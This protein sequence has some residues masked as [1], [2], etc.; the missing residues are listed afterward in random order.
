MRRFMLVPAL[1][2][3]CGIGSPVQAG[4]R[5]EADPQGHYPITPGI[6]AFVIC[7]ACFTGDEAPD[8]ARQL[9]Y[10]IR[11]NYN[12]PAY[13]FNRGDEERRRQQEELEAVQRLNLQVN[14]NQPVRRRT[15]RIEEQ[16]AVLVGG[17]PDMETGR[18]AL[19]QIKAMKVNELRLRSGQS[20]LDVMQTVKEDGTVQRSFVNPFTTAFVTRN[21]SIPPD[22]INKF[23]PQL[24]V[25][26]ADEEYS[27]LKCPQRW[28][29]AVKQ[30]AGCKVVQTGATPTGGFL[31]NL[32]PGPNKPGASLDA[33][34]LQ[35]HELA[36]VL[37]QLNF[38]SFVLH[39]RTNSLVTVGAFTSPDDPNIKR[40]QHQLASLQ[41]RL[42]PKDPLQLLPT[43]IP[44]EVPRQPGRVGPG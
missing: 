40:V 13:L 26:N 10:Q 18:L 23:D 19:D 37:R 15:I 41:E 28:T 17:Y 31:K 4:P 6:G 34:G 20:A 12:V 32:L 35:A 25:F 24:L 2:L 9:V 42:K 8:L 22:Q 11:A 1:V 29:L 14:Q 5:I 16:C 39:T 44:M 33:A 38:Q 7:A 27:L 36:R 21:P 43:P 3:V 30:Y